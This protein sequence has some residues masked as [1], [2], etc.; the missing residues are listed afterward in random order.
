MQMIGVTT[1]KGNGSLFGKSK[2]WSSPDMPENLEYPEVPVNVDGQLY[3]DPLTFICQI[4]CEDLA[5]HDPEGL[6]PHGGMLWFFA[7]LD[8]FLGDQDADAA[9]GMGE[10]SPQYFKVLYSKDCSGLHTHS[11]L[12][13]DGTPACLPEEEIVF[14]EGGE[15]CTGFLGKPYFEEVREAMP[16]MLSLLQIDG[17]DRWNL[18]FFDCGMLN[19]LISAEDLAE[20]R[21]DRVR[22]YLH[23]F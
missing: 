19:F 23:S 5:A 6:L 15:S 12:Y 20:R 1:T 16:G 17:E 4:R 13:D 3:Y 2:W 21:F 18:R 11:V 10:W 8:Y 9:P 14:R 22:C 7:A